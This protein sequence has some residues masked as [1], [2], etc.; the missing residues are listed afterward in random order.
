VLLDLFCSLSAAS[1]LS[2]TAK[3]SRVEARC[4]LRSGLAAYLSWSVPND[5][6]LD[7]LCAVS[8]LLEV[9]AGTGLWASLLRS[10]GADVIAVD[11]ADSQAGQAWRFRHSCVVDGC[12]IEAAGAAGSEKRTLMLCWPDEMEDGG[13]VDRKFGAAC[14]AAYRGDTVAIIGESAPAVCRA[15]PGFGASSF[16]AAGSSCSRQLQRALKVSF[17]PIRRVML[18]NWP[19][20]NS[21]LTVWRRKG[22]EGG[23]PARA[24]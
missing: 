4:Q 16:A 9:G 15:Q 1:P 18:P 7:V 13:E 12:G 10:R 19:P 6:A 14:L 20:Y 21:H 3:P 11:L 8:P 5:E 23:G 24:D 22:S 17:R 2:L